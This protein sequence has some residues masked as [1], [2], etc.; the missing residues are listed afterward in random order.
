MIIL[1]VLA[2][3]DEGWKYNDATKSC[4]FLGTGKQVKFM[5]A[6]R[7]CRDMGSTL[8]SVHSEAENTFIL[9]K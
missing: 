1:S 3:C 2:T 8:A 6:Q 4:Y 9:G 5:D 7:A